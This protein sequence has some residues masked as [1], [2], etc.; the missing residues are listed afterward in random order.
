[1]NKA[2]TQIS[3][4]D[5]KLAQAVARQMATKMAMQCHIDELESLCCSLL[6]SLLAK[7]N[8]TET[9]T[10]Y[11]KKSLKGYCMNY[12]R[13]LGSRPL[14]DLYSAYRRLLKQNPSSAKLSIAIIAKQLACSES[15]LKEAIAHIRPQQ[16]NE[17]SSQ[18][19]LF[20][21]YELAQLSI[22]KDMLGETEYNSLLEAMEQGKDCSKQIE[23]LKEKLGCRN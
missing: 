3:S 2:N 22:I 14:Q 7:I 23:E 18:Q 8:S 11:I 5:I 9:K 15:L 16:I 17:N 4:E 10:G 19:S 6:P 1:M 21:S 13:S 12:A 20:D